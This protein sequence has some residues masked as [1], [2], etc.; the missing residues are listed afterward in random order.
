MLFLTT[1]LKGRNEKEKKNLQSGEAKV[2]F[3]VKYLQFTKYLLSNKGR[4]VCFGNW[5]T[6]YLMAG[7]DTR[8]LKRKPLNTAQANIEHIHEQVETCLR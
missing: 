5:V 6:C 1:K 4:C 8:C 2:T 7:K 3:S